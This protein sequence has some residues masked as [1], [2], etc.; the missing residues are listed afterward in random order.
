MSSFNPMDFQELIGK[1]YKRTHD[2]TTWELM[3]ILLA[4]K[5]DINMLQ[6]F[7]KA[8]LSD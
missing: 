7:V 3:G 2:C 4:E 8:V 6:I 5:D 1:K